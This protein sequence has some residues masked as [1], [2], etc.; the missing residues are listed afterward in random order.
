VTTL[1]SPVVMKKQT[2][3]DALQDLAK[4]GSA[5]IRKIQEVCVLVTL[6]VHRWHGKDKADE[7]EVQ[8]GGNKVGKRISAPQWEL[9][10]KKWKET[11]Q[12]VESKARSILDFYSIRSPIRGS[13]FVPLRKAE[14]LFE[15]LANIRAELDAAADKFCTPEEYEAMIKDLDTDLA[16]SAWVAQRHLP[17]LKDLRGKFGMDWF[18]IP[19]AEPGSAMTDNSSLYVKEA[20][21]TLNKVV[22]ESVE[23]MVKEPRQNLADAVA[24]LKE[25]V[26]K[27]SRRIRS[28]TINSVR[29][30][31]QEY[32][33]WAFMADDQTL[34]ALQE[35]EGKLEGVK[36]KEI[37]SNQSVADGLNVGLTALQNQLKDEDAILHGFNK[38]RRAVKL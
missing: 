14:E 9:M 4:Q 12:A 24:R 36:P 17:L 35:L 22:M 3:D 28:D 11:F 8:C 18:V 37:N 19:I 34:T 30:A 29:S 31:F 21:A 2:L 7:V 20:Q 23:A 38:F 33:N 25:Q 1:N 6:R 27:D 16:G 32:Q 13:R 10:P 15:K 5:V 26:S